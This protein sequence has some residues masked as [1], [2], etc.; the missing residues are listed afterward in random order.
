MSIAG[1]L[2]HAR[3]AG[4]T[5]WLKE[6]IRSDLGFYGGF[7]A[8]I[9][10]TALLAAIRGE[11]IFPQLAEYGE[12]IWRVLL[13]AI[14]GLLLVLCVRA[15]INGGEGS[16][17]ANIFA[18]FKAIVRLKF[19]RFLYAC[20]LMVFFMAAFLY[21]KMDIPVLAPFDWDATFAGWEAALFG[22]RQPW[23]LIHPFVGY[24]PITILLDLLYSSWVV[25]TFVV[26]AALL[27]SV[28]TPRAVRIRYWRATVISWVVIG[29]V[30][31]T[32]LSSA[33]P[34]YFGRFEPT[35]TDPFAELNAYL[36]HVDTIFPLSQMASR[37]LLWEVY[38]NRVDLPG[39]ISA[40]PSMHNAQAALFA[41]V[42]FSL[43]RRL[44]IAMTA[45][46]VLIFIGSIHLGWHYALD[47][48]V[49]CAV[50]LAIWWACGL[51][52]RSADA[53]KAE[54]QPA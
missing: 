49:G 17:L 22:G 28:R 2:D 50:A 15:L 16:L 6:E 4:F 39:G 37:E 5:R 9:A 51:R 27:A 29:I 31:A 1:T 47:G 20:G 35:L 42:G 21:H 40:M 48:V 53:S 10:G 36:A 32:L 44:G 13:A 18:S 54:M 7:I 14:C 23:E 11:S 30:M 34:L 38:L 8:F 33:G 52:L 45:Y 3:P 19:A 24:P 25:M 26:W 46:A 41:A 43:S 12:R